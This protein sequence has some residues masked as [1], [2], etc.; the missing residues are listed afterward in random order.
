MFD[1]GDHRVGHATVHDGYRHS[2]ARRARPERSEGD[3]QKLVQNS[4]I[5][6]QAALP[7]VGLVRWKSMLLDVVR[8]CWACRR[9]ALLASGQQA[10]PGYKKVHLRDFGFFPPIEPIS[11]SRD[12]P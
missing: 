9:G 11:R 5:K 8:H 10:M 4:E 3:A 7:I 2:A 12:C 1:L 6:I